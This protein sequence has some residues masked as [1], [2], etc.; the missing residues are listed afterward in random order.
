M[1]TIVAQEAEAD[2]S[3]YSALIK[4]GLKELA[5]IHKANKATDLEI[6]R[7]QASTRKKLNRIRENLRYV[8][9]AR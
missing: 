9:A 4:E 6:R 2:A 7:L 1:K 5:V 3:G 8:H